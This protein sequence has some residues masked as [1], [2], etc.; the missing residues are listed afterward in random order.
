MRDLQEKEMSMLLYLNSS[1]VVSAGWPVDDNC[2]I[3]EEHKHL[4]VVVF[5]G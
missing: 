3:P 5:N 1:W 4:S 2:Y